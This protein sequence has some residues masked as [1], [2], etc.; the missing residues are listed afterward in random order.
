V[1]FV[2]ADSAGFRTLQ[3][4]GERTSEERRRVRG[5]RI[6]I[7]DNMDKD[8]ILVSKCRAPKWDSFRSGVWLR[9]SGNQSVFRS[10]VDTVM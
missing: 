7:C 8:N 2:S 4:L 10:G 1:F 3:T 6:S 9:S 5:V